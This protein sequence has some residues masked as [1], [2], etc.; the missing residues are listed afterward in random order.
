MTVRVRFAP[1]PTGTL[2]IGGARTALFNWLFARHHKGEF[3]L[4]VEDTD[5]ERSLPEHTKSILDGMK[6][7][8]MDWDADLVYQSE[9]SDL[10][11]SAIDKLLSEKKAYKC[12]CT[13]EE[14]QVKRDLAMKEGRKPL[15]DRTCREK[16]DDLDKP[17][18][19]RIKAPIDGKTSYEDVCRGRI[20]FLN[21]ELDDLIIARSDGSPTYN[22]VVVV[23][24]VDMKITH[25]VRGDD[26]INN[27]PKQI[28]V[29]N[30]LNYDLPKFAHLPMIFGKDKKKLSKRHGATSVVEY[31]DMGFLPEAMMNYI[32]RLGW[33]HGDDEIF[34][35]NE[36]I[37]K[38]DLNGVGSS[39]SVFDTEKLEWVNQQHILKK[40]DKELADLVK[41]FLEQLGLNAA[42]KTYNEKVMSV[43]KERGKTLIEIAEKSICFFGEDLEIDD[44][45][46]EKWFNRESI[47]WL[48]TFKGKLSEM[49]SVSEESISRIF[50]EGMEALGLKMVKLAQP[51][52]VALTGTTASPGIFDVISILGRET[53]LTR[54]SL[55]IEDKKYDR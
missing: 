38:F 54:L 46:A 48:K 19:I 29:Y 14:L 6:W 37:E 30:A 51:I 15:Y 17:F 32:A 43:M 1:S 33:A 25:V 9:R 18:V 36:L 41:P 10:Y 16:S 21:T 8:C 55:I 4:R 11:K 3:Y 44:V 2:H 12:Y 28:V 49:D 22:F 31:K 34:T 7:L 53:V 26:H 47:N 5:I 20:E 27:T 42:D 45:A 50:K 23:D 35:I 24:D 39:P 40:S 13:Q 52:R